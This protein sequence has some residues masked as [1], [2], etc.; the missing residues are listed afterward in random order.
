MSRIELEDSADFVIVG[1]GAGGATAARV[2]SEAG[3]SVVM[4]EEGPH[5]RPEDRAQ[6]LLEAL[7]QSLRDFGTITTS[8]AAPIPLLLGRCVGGSTAVNSGIIWRMPEPVRR[9]WV[10]RF[11]LGTL[12]DGRALE[13]A[14]EQIERDLGV[15]EVREHVRGGNAERMEDAARRMR[16]PGRYVRRNA[17]TC[18]GSARCLQGCPHGARLSMEVSY[19]PRALAAGARLHALARARRIEIAEGRAAAVV[20][21]LL[22]A[23]TRR[24]RG[25]FRISARRAVIVSA[26]AIHTPVLLRQSGLRGLVGER[27]QAHPG[28]AIVG[29][30][31]EPVGM[32][33]G[34]TQA[35]EI[36]LRARRLKI[37][38]LSLPPEL[39][40]ARLPGAGARW[41]EALGELDHFAQWCAIVR[42]RAHGRVRPGWRGGA[43][44]RYEPLARDVESVREGVVLLARLMFAAG[45]CEVYPGVAGWPEML[46]RP[47]QVEALV[48]APV[49]RRDFHL[50]ASHHF[51]T[52]CAG[53]DQAASVVGPD[54]QAHD[55]RGLYVM[56]ASVFPTNLGVNPQHSIMAVVTLAAERLAQSSAR[57][58]AA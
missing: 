40:A 58:A 21:E 28:A 9:S 5:L 14:F 15:A 54:L 32:G 11:G 42:M 1:T 49:A 2:L 52:A 50:V 18:R 4:L 47:E 44:V 10:L 3:H 31:D 27:L 37:E 38:S 53:S 34:A 43:Q 12:V 16:L 29:R 36:P 13:R 24:V 55:V 19:V 26:G 22:N 23:D 25:R 8:G 51:G 39:L 17:P 30:F 7:G 41:Q 56:D 35:Y 57:R 48:D 33:F 45:A 20:G 6:P 46:D